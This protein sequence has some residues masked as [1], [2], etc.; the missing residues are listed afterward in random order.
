MAFAGNTEAMLEADATDQQYI[1]LVK[2]V[3]SGSR[4]GC[5]TEVAYTNRRICVSVQVLYLPTHEVEVWIGLYLYEA[6]HYNYGNVRL[7]GSSC[8]GKIF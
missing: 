6:A 5:L 2:T 8:C 4:K 7:V 1:V 3:G